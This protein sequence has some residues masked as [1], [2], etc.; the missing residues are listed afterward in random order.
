MAIPLYVLFLNRTLRSICTVD[1]SQSV[2]NRIPL[3]TRSNPVDTVTM[4]S[5]PGPGPSSG[6]GSI[7]RPVSRARGSEVN[8]ALRGVVEGDR[9]INIFCAISRI[10]PKI[11]F[12]K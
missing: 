1:V 5:T 10:S 12:L 9:G 11:G 4:E 2:D 7:P 3:F 6:P 8:M